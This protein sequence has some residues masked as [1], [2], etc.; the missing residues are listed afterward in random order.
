MTRRREISYVG[1]ALTGIGFT[2]LVT[3][4]WTLHRGVSYGVSKVRAAKSNLLAR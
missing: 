4:D 2:S 1:K 3:V